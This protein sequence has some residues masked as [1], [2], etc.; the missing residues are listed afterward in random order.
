MKITL[1]C[2]GY[3]GEG[4]GKI[5]EHLQK[6]GS[7]QQLIKLDEDEFLHGVDLIFDGLKISNL[8]INTNDEIEYRT[9]YT[10]S[11][12]CTYQVARNILKLIYYLKQLGDGGH[13]YTVNIN[14]EKF[15]WDGDGSDRVFEI[16]GKDCKSWKK[17]EKDFYTY[18][19]KEDDINEEY[20]IESLLHF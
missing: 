1:K 20:F 12:T 16:N 8:D 2:G 15:S 13:S 19:K 10:A 17:M 18:I 5:L 14:G 11:F 6:N 3:K 9:Q 7:K 4:M